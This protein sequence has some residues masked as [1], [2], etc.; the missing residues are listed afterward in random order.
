MTNLFSLCLFLIFI[1]RSC[2]SLKGVW[3]AASGDLNSPMM[4]SHWNV[5]HWNLQPRCLENISVCRHNWANWGSMLTPTVLHLFLSLTSCVCLLVV[6]FLEL[7][8][9]APVD[10]VLVKPWLFVPFWCG[11]T[12]TICMVFVTEKTWRS[13]YPEARSRCLKSVQAIEISEDFIPGV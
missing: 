13:L 5:L 3:E 12:D 6:V 8:T 1:L 4:Q 2:F 10:L 9:R 11:L 7:A